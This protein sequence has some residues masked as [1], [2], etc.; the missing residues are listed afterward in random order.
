MKGRCYECYELERIPL[1]ILVFLH[2]QDL[3][4][5]QARWKGFDDVIFSLA[6]SQPAKKRNHNTA[7]K[8]KNIHLEGTIVDLA[9]Y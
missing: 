6:L 7:N 3:H 5:W 2:A 4:P 8:E 1:L 9:S